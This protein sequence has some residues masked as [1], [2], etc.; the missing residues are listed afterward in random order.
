MTYPDPRRQPPGPLPPQPPSYHPP[1]GGF[2]ATGPLPAPYPPQPPKKKG[3]STGAIIGI[4]IGG[5]VAVC[6]L[7][8]IIVAATSD[9]GKKP[10]SQAA[11]QETAAAQPGG[12][13]TQ[14]AGNT[15]V[16][17][18]ATT[19]APV[20]TS[21]VAAAGS[22]VRDGKFEFKVT[23]GPDCGKTQIG[24][25]KAQGRYCQ[26]TLSIKNIGNDARTFDDSNVVAYDAAGARYETDGVAGMYANPNGESFLEKINPGNQVSAVMVF[27]VA[28]SITLTTLELHD[29][30]FSGGAKV[31]L[32]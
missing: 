16:A 29:S 26:I 12:N 30:M 7:G 11:D 24:G 22:A 6:C 19:G 14:P 13:T 31:A 3:L 9:S 1:T 32:A 23:K 4:V 10:G 21:N 20:K 18:K 28:A 27:D 8:G 15:A 5:I 2:P 17:P 25:Q